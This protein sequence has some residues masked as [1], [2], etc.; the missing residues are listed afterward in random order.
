[1]YRD[2]FIRLGRVA[3]FEADL[4]LYQLR[5]ASG[6]NINNILTSTERNQT[7]GHVRDTYKRYYTPTH[8]ARDF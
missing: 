6:S 7:M 4:E 1:K 2:I 3:G 8:I 5:R